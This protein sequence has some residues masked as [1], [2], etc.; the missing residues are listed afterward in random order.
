MAQWRLL[1]GGENT[2]TKLRQKTDKRK[3]CE[4]KF[5]R[6]LLSWWKA[7]C[8]SGNVNDK[9]NNEIIAMCS[10]ITKFAADFSCA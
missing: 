6:L 4:A 7:G 8:V 3:S 1:R 2:A 5:P 10:K 9:E